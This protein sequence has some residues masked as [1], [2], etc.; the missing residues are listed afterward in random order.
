MSYNEKLMIEMVKQPMGGSG[1]G[2]REGGRGGSR[3]SKVPLSKKWKVG[4]NNPYNGN[5][6]TKI[7]ELQE[8]G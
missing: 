2:G 7:Q 1:G 8:N 3:R 4:N 6:F 5:I